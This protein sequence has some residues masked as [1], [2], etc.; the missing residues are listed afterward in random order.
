M[1]LEEIT[2][3]EALTITNVSSIVSK[4]RPSQERV[5]L[6]VRNFDAANTITITISNDKGAVVN[7]GIP[8]KPGDGVAF[9]RQQGYVVP[10]TN[11]TAIGSAASAVA[12]LSVFERFI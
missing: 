2:R 10:Q 9:S 6:V 1:A 11:I 4:R 8:L 7:E 3:N 5:D 12:N